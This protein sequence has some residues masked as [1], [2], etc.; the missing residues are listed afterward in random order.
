[1]KKK[2]EAQFRRCASAVPSLIASMFDI[3]SVEAQL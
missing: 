2:E 3:R 1:M